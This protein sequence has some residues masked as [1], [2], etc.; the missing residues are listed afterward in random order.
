MKC[1]MHQ[2]GWVLGGL[3]GEYITLQA[4]GT[5]YSGHLSPK[6]GGGGVGLGCVGPTLQECKAVAMCALCWQT[7]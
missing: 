1:I 3:V 4:K 6:N 7:R 5:Q 2:V